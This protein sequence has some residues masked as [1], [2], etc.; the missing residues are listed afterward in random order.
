MKGGRE[1]SLYLFKSL[2]HPIGFRGN[3][4]VGLE[5]AVEETDVFKPER[6]GYL[7]DLQVSNRQLCLGIGQ[8]GIGD[9]ISCRAVAHGFD[10]CAQ[11]GQGDVNRLRKVDHMKQL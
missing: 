10:G 1:N 7:L 9:N 2:F 8:D 4:H 3:P 6:Q 5:E 11:E